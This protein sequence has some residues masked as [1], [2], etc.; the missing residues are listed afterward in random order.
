MEKLTDALTALT[1]QMAKMEKEISNLKEEVSHLQEKITWFGSRLPEK[2][3]KD[4]EKTFGQSKSTQ[5]QEKV[6]GTML[7]GGKPNIGAKL[8]S[9]KSKDI[10]SSN[11]IAAKGKYFPL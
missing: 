3:K 5:K 7:F 9:E 2:D 11:I 4:Y 1:A 6:E 8:E 10:R